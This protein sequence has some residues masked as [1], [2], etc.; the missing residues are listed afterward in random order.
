MKRSKSSSN[1][2]KT[3]LELPFFLL[4]LV[5]LILLFSFGGCAENFTPLLSPEKNYLLQNPSGQN[6]WTNRKKP[7]RDVVSKISFVKE[8]E[9]NYTNSNLWQF[10][11]VSENIYNIKSK[12]SGSLETDTTGVH[13]TGFALSGNPN[14]EYEIKPTDNNQW[15]IKNVGINQ[16]VNND[17]SLSPDV[18]TN[19]PWI[20]V[21]IS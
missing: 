13:L 1:R 17:L 5:I 8:N 3:N 9:D 14:F 2:L 21:P 19:T 16:Y 18:T 6:L 12:T 11:P 4:F 10:E 20:L 7:M 15:L